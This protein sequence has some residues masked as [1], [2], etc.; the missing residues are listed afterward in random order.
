M[1][2]DSLDVPTG[3][4]GSP[5]VGFPGLTR[6]KATVCGVSKRAPSFF[7]LSGLITQKEGGYG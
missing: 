5:Y 4:E 7:N 2:Y 1:G 3:C 6:H